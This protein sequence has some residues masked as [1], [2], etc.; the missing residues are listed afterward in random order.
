AI[1]FRFDSAGAGDALVRNQN[2][3]QFSAEPVLALHDVALEDD[4]ASVARTDDARNRRLATVRA[5]DGVVAPER[6]RV[7]IVQIGHRFA[8]LAC[9]ALADV[10]S[11]PLGM[12][13]VC[14]ASGAELAC[15]TGGTGSVEADGDH[16]IQTNA[17]LF[18]G[19][20]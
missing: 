3:T 9:Q 19:E 16:V 6:G 7:G 8:Q 20:L 10:V 13:K 1:A 15:G 18:S 14:G 2:V 12:N 17:R 11:G 4:A 5:E